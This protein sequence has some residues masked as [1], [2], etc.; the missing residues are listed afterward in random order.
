MYQYYA[1][2]V[3]NLRNNN[4]VLVSAL[5]QWARTADPQRVN[6]LSSILLN[7]RFGSTYTQMMNNCL[8]RVYAFPAC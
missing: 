1:P 4:Q 2:T 5:S 7:M 3:I 8:N 6:G